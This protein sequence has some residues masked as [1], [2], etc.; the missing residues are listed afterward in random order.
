MTPYCYLAGVSWPWSIDFYKLKT[1]LFASYHGMDA[2]ELYISWE[3][4][5]ILDASEEDIREVW[6][7]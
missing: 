1:D 6:M 7:G 4:I 3:I 2:T 5:I